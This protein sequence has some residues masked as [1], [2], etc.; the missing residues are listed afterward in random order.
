[1]QRLSFFLTSWLLIF[2]FAKCSKSLTDNDKK[3]IVGFTDMADLATVEYTLSKIVKANDNSNWFTIGNRK[4]VMSVMAY[5]KAGIDLSKI[6]TNN[7]N[8]KNGTLFIDIPPAKLISLS[9]PPEEIKEEMAEV[10]SLRQA[11]TNQEKEGLLK[12]AEIDIRKMIDSIGIINKAE[13]NAKTFIENF[14]NDLGY[15]NVKVQTNPKL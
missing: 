12:Q 11:F 5:A 14:V 6:T 13:L 8:S 7:V 9:I 3:A 2:G 10:G 15:K 4:I 1:M